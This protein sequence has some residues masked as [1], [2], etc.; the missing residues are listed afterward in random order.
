[1]ATAAS[2]SPPETGKDYAKEEESEDEDSEEEDEPKLKYERISGD[3]RDILKRD[4]ASCI[5]ANS[6]LII[7]GT[8]W[9]RIHVLDHQGNK[10]KGFNPHSSPV[11]MIDMDDNGGGPRPIHNGEFSFID[12]G[13]SS[14]ECSFGPSVSQATIWSSLCCWYQ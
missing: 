2:P 1:M 12:Y 13:F 5:A 6:K 9:G 10:V 14:T 3:L 11:T 4:G 7:I 8:N